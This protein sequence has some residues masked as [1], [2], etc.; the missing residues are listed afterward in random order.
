MLTFS[1]HE[2]GVVCAPAHSHIVVEPVAIRPDFQRFC[3]F[4]LKQKDFKNEA[5][6]LRKNTMRI[7]L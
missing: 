6:L 2:G 3:D 7:F 5:I 4:Y 1:Q